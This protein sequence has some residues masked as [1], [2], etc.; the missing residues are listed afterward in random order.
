MV[1]HM[2]RT[3]LVAAVIAVPTGAAA[4]AIT[5]AAGAISS[6]DPAP[7]DRF[8]EPTYVVSFQGVITR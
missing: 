1:T 3:A 8:I 4:Q 6:T 5:F 7:A 2:L